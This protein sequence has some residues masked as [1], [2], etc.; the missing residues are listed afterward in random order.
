MHNHSFELHR[1][2]VWGCAGK[3]HIKLA[4][5]D[6]ICFS[7]MHHCFQRDHLCMVETMRNAQVI[8]CWLTQTHTDLQKSKGWLHSWSATEYT[9]LWHYETDTTDHMS[10]WPTHRALC[11]HLKIDHPNWLPHT[12][13]FTKTS[14]RSIS[15][16]KG[17]AARWGGG[18]GCG[19]YSYVP[20]HSKVWLGHTALKVQYVC[21]CD[22][23]QHA[24]PFIHPHHPQTHT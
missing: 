24:P 6:N 15:M 12:D 22:N 20:L 1:S 13:G 3:R 19:G 14:E 18:V 10:A 8:R 5:T 17:Q 16:F 7:S 4:M 21:N 2:N 11:L 23:F 9:S